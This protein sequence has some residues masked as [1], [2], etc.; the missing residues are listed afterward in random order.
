[1]E[2]VPAPGIPADYFFVNFSTVGPMG[3]FGG[4][5]PNLSFGTSSPGIY[6]DSTPTRLV[7]PP[8]S[9]WIMEIVLTETG[10]SAWAVGE[11]VTCNPVDE[12]NGQGGGTLAF[13]FNKRCEIAQTRKVD[14]KQNGIFFKCTAA[15]ILK[16]NM[17]TGNNATA[18]SFGGYARGKRIA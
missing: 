3:S 14:E 15:G 5:S 1:M 13:G 2:I 16:F 6:I 18:R 7:L 12:S 17:S 9:V 11:T 4:G 10:A 8:G